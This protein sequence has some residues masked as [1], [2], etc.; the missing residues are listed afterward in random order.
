MSIFTRNVEAYNSY[1]D[2]FLEDLPSDKIRNKVLK[3]LEILISIKH[4]NSKFLKKLQNADDLFEL[5]VSQGSN[6]YRLLG[7]FEGEDYSDHFI[8]LNCFLKKETKDYKPIIQKAL[9]LKFEYYEEE[10]ED[11]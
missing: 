9:Q 5:R 6:E 11:D 10:Q 7:F 8:I 3:V 1:F 4:P 2:E